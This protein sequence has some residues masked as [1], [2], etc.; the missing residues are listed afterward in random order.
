MKK[1]SSS[2]KSPKRL[3]AEA[4]QEILA[5]MGRKL[6]S[7]PPLTRDGHAAAR[8]KSL[9]DLIIISQARRMNETQHEA[10]IRKAQLPRE[11]PMRWHKDADPIL[12]DL[13]AKHPKRSERRNELKKQWPLKEDRTPLPEN[14]A[15][16][17]HIKKLDER[18]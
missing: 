10:Q 16:D 6:Q 9:S 1:S 18:K 13:R 15:I 14:R 17:E 2:G 11:K 7:L 4:W 5:T 8:E 12:I 3:S